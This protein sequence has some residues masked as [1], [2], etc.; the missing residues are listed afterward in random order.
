[1]PIFVEQAAALTPDRFFFFPLL[2][3]AACWRAASQS[4][5][6]VICRTH[7]FG[8][9]FF[10]EAEVTTRADSIVRFTPFHL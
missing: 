6:E 10:L 4:L 2:A 3:P 7:L 9:V 1:M 5:R 8:T